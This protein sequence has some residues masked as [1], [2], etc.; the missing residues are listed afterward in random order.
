MPLGDVPAVLELPWAL[1][2][3]DG[4]EPGL[5]EPELDDPEPDDPVFGVDEFG[6]PAVPGK[7]PHGEP[8]G[9]VPGVLEVFGFTVD[10]CVLLPGV[11]GLVEFEPGTVDEEPGVALPA[12]GVA[13]PV[14]GG[15]EVPVG[16]ATDPVGEVA[17]PG[18]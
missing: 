7:V 4:D 10:G 18:A 11:A 15:V 5:D 12:G 17:V 3:V 9:V 16:G 6:V 14:G 13:V 2:E 1:P 8:L